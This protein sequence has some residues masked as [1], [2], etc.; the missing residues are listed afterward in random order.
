MSRKKFK[1]E[2]LARRHKQMVLF[3]R[4]YCKSIKPECESCKLK[5]ICNKKNT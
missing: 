4:Y 5:D 3:G 1:K 2:E